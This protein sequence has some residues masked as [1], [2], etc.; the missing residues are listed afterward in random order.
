MML[1]LGNLGLFDVALV[2]LFALAVLAFI[3][4]ILIRATRR[5]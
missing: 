5:K 2:C 4:W 1:F 3:A